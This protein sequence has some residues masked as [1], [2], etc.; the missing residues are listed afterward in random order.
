MTAFTYSTVPVQQECHDVLIKLQF[1]FG[2]PQLC[3]HLLHFLLQFLSSADRTFSYR[4]QP[5]P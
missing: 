5:P 1:L 3:L 2:I 4:L